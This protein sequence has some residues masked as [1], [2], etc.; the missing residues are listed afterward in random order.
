LA[1]PE[2]T[3]VAPNTSSATANPRPGGE[4]AV[5]PRFFGGGARFFLRNL[6][7]LLVNGIAA[8]FIGFLFRA[9]GQAMV[10]PLEDTLSA[11]LAWVR[12]LLPLALPSVVVFFFLLVNDYAS[13]RLVVSDSRRPVR[14][15]LSALG[16]VARRFVASASIWISVGLILGLV[17]TAYVAFRNTVAATTWLGIAWMIAIQQTFMLTRAT[18][19]IATVS[20]ELNY[21][22]KQGFVS[23]PR[24]AAAGPERPG[25]G[26]GEQVI[27]SSLPLAPVA[28]ERVV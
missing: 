20:A 6:V 4:R 15:W 10:R 13:I 12:L 21:A 1:S 17:L 25:A 7:I 28:E 2:V 19:R 16:F 5:L 26:A 3:A 22:T 8:A 11:P 23:V 18:L 24:G 27:T 9:A 14:T